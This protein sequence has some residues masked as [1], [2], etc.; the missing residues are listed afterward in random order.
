[1]TDAATDSPSLERR[2]QVLVIGAGRRVQNN[3]LPAF[4]VLGDSFEV[5]GVHARTAE[6]LLPVARLWDVPA[7]LRL[8]DV[9]LSGVDM[10]A[11]SVP[12]SQNAA[13][14]ASLA[15]RGS[16]L[17]IVIDTPI[18]ANRRELAA[19]WPLLRRFAGVTVTEDYMNK[20][21]F[22]L[23]RQAVGDGVIGRP[24]GAALY[25]IGYQYHG[26]ALLR[27]LIGFP[28]VRRVRRVAL[29]GFSRIVTYSF[30]NGFRASIVGPYRRRRTGGI[31]VEGT[32]GLITEVAEDINFGRMA[33]R[34]LYHLS[35]L[36][37][38][39]ELTGYMLA[40]GQRHYRADL[41]EMAAMRAMPIADKSDLNLLRGCGLIS[42]LRSTI[43]VPDVNSAYG[44]DNALY[45]S[46]VSRLA[47]RGL[48]PV[49][50]LTW[51]G[52]NVMALIRA[53][54]WRPGDGRSFNIRGG[55]S[56]APTAPAYP[57]FPPMPD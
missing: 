31:V 27:S 52:G 48:L 42:V 15:T 43:G 18:A 54:S 10:V 25:N 13:V 56:R 51:F 35:P 47:E 49:D 19:T 50:P 4:R 23:V 32:A 12:T 57:G 21:H 3:F 8:S 44:A 2:R 11:V 45:D 36:R 46:F 22:G 29:G 26:L 1:M 14:L 55:A 24:L 20:P 17:C 39:G 33:G 28:R 34:D 53:M 37:T 41:P 5:V 9:D 6:R 38:D 16:H 40:G 30:A 7:I